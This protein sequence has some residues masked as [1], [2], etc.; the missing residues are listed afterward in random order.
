MVH[1]HGLERGSVCAAGRAR[2]V[3]A[4]RRCLGAHG[5]DVIGAIRRRA[6]GRSDEAGLS[7]N[8]GTARKAAAGACARAGARAVTRRLTNRKII[9]LFRLPWLVA[10]AV[11]LR[12]LRRDVLLLTLTAAVIGPV[13]TITAA[14]TMPTAAAMHSEA[15][16]SAIALVVPVLSRILLRLAAA[17]GDESRQAADLVT[18]F[19]RAALWRLRL[20]LLLRPILEL[21]VTWREGL[22]IPRQVRLRLR[23][24]RRVARLVLPHVRLAVIIVAVKAFIGRALRLTALATLLR[25]LIVVGVLLTELFLGGGDQAEIVFG[26][27]III[28]G[29]NRIAGTLRI[30]CKLDIFFRNMRCGT[31]DLHVWTV[32]LINARQRVLTLA[33]VS[34]SPHA[35]LTV[36][37]DV[38]V[39]RPFTFFRHSPPNVQLN[40]RLPCSTSRTKFKNPVQHSNTSHCAAGPLS[41]Q[42]Q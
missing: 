24:P 25:L 27:L 7:R 37:H 3:S 19:V 4:H 1:P 8:S 32:R 39:R 30:T 40:F 18:A 6:S 26:V 41:C 2:L 28:L 22:R 42:R 9:R 38:P 16:L 21:L 5:R 10:A 14:T 33:V 20:G 36:S 13:G 31:T 29:R 11:V 15:I 35:L 23:F 17:A 12:R 34:A